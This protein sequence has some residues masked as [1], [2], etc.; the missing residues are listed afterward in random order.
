[1]MSV[2]QRE[3][4]GANTGVSRLKRLRTS[5]LNRWSPQ[6]FVYHHVPKCGGTSVGTALRNRYIMSQATVTPE[7][8][9]RAFEAFSGRT[10]R[11]QMLV[12]ILDL[13]E[14]MLLYHLL[15]DVRGLSLHVRFSAPAHRLFADKYK[16]ITLL[17]EPVGRFISHYFY[18]HGKP[19]AHAN[20]EEDLTAFLETERA[21]R[22]GAMYVEYFC[23]LPKEADLTAPA[24][25]ASAKANL[26]KFDLI[27]RLDRMAAFEQNLREVLGVKIRI[28]HDNKARQDADTRKS[29]VTPELRARIEQLCAPDLEIWESFSGD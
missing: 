23:G 7:A 8:S 27:G 4:Q 3:L 28:G 11:E 18:S 2:P 10:D 20:I 22:F 17:R 16:F 24:S 29:I 13:R 12:D 25:I 9:F 5:M 14:Q 19:W 26:R 21:R 15:E 1:M 6:R